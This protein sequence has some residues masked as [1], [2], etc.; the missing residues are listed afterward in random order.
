MLTY[1]R[2]SAQQQPKLQGKKKK[3]QQSDE[4]IELWQRSGSPSTTRAEAP[5]AKLLE[6]NNGPASGTNTVVRLGDICM[7]VIFDHLKD[8]IPS[9]VL[10]PYPLRNQV[11]SVA[12]K[13][14]A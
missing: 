11:L 6:I 1:G 8:Y 14:G 10:L 4:P 12:L 3:K 9:L 2:T 5:K 13:N 7:G